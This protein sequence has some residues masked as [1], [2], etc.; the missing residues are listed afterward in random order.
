MHKP[1]NHESGHEPE[2]IDASAGF[3]QSDVKVTGILVF[4]T[5][6]GIFVVVTAVL[7]Y[8]IGKVIN[9]RM[10]Q[11]DGPDTKWT[12]TVDIRQLGN[13]PNNPDMQNKVARADAAVSPRRGCRSTTATRT[14]PTCTRA[15]ICC[16][17]TTAGSTQ[18]IPR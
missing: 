6:L 9:A 1:E 14:W 13:L 4:L 2:K 11:E 16:W 12:K 10:N 15:R 17:T 8:G 7:C 3:E 18:R 5:A